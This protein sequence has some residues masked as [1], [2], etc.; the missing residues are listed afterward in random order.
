MMRKGRKLEHNFTSAITVAKLCANVRLATHIRGVYTRLDY[1]HG[2]LRAASHMCIPG[3][4]GPRTFH[5]TEAEV[6]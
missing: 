1:M 5:Q 6:L 2:D 3:G 4:S